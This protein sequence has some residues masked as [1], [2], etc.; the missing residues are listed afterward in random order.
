MPFELHTPTVTNESITI[1]NVAIPL[2]MQKGW[3]YYRNYLKFGGTLK[4][5]EYLMTLSIQ[6]KDVRER[7]EEVARFF[8]DQGPFIYLEIQAGEQDWELLVHRT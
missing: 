7:H 1:D 3:E 2:G 4:P 8:K 5:Q 6:F